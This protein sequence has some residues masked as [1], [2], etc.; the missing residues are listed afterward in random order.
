MRQELSVNPPI[1]E[2]R[3]GQSRLL[4]RLYR[5]VGLAAVYAELELQPDA[6]DADTAAAVERGLTLLVAPS[7]AI[8]AA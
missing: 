2:E 5:E 7:G 8:L 6:L 4:S 3:A 1:I